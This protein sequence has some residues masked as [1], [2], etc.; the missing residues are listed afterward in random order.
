[1]IKSPIVSRFLANPSRMERLIAQVNEMRAREVL[2]RPR[3]EMVEE[4]DAL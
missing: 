4:S 3:F 1:M 2:E